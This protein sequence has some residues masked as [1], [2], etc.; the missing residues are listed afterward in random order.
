[1]PE[2]LR[3]CRHSR[4]ALRSRGCAVLAYALA[5]LCAA[6]PAVLDLEP[7]SELPDA[8]QAGAA[9]EEAGVTDG[10]PRDRTVSSTAEPEGATDCGERLPPPALHDAGAPPEEL[11]G[12]RSASFVGGAAGA[13]LALRA[14]SAAGYM[15]PCGPEHTHVLQVPGGYELS[16][17]GQT[18]LCPPFDT[19]L[20]R[21][22]ISNSG[23]IEVRD[24]V[25]VQPS[26]LRCDGG[27]PEPAADVT[28]PPLA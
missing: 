12:A 22:F 10:S 14:V 18:G 16:A 27:V 8:E 26:Q 15:L 9:V 1:M 6:C 3:Q 24:G 13:E 4:A 2:N 5:S 7:E 21:L 11:G 17:L 20:Y 23:Q 28:E 19:M 25:A